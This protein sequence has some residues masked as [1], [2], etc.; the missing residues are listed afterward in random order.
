MLGSACGRSRTREPYPTRS[1]ARPCGCLPSPFTL[2]LAHRVPDELWWFCFGRQQKGGGKSCCFNI[3]MIDGRDGRGDGEGGGRGRKQLPAACHC[4][5]T[6]A[7]LGGARCKRL[8]MKW[9]KSEAAQQYSKYAGRL[10]GRAG[11]CGAVQS[12]V[13]DW[14]AASCDPSLQCMRS[15]GNRLW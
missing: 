5:L 7:G 1:V 9:R 15:K 12:I 13:S 3:L 2:L 14:L 8:Q 11:R 4:L 10:C 6:G